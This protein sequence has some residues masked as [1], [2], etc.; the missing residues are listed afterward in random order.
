[1]VSRIVHSESVEI[2]R[3]LRLLLNTQK[4]ELHMFIV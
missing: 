4:P 2:V 1:M 3:R